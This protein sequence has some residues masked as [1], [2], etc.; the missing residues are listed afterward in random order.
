VRR[1]LGAG[2]ESGYVAVD[3]AF[4]N[5]SLPSGGEFAACPSRPSL[6]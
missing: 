6:P 1:A 3:I 5:H 2:A 4:M